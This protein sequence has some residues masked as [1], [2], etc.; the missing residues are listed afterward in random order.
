M[1]VP[2]PETGD[3]SR[4]QRRAKKRRSGRLALRALAVLAVVALLGGIAWV[5]AGMVDDDPTPRPP[6]APE[7]DAAAQGPGPALVVLTDD[8]GEVYA[9]TILVPDTS[10]IVHV[11]PGTLVEVP[12][13]GLASLAE[14][15][16]E[17]GDDL[18]RQSL[19]NL[20][21]ARLEH[22]LRLDRAALGVLLTDV[23]PLS[24]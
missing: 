5:V 18:V 12:S 23:A 9:L 13:L 19:E 1:T 10:T 3:G 16:A 4:R 15:A 14:A 24:V 21:G 11:P 17:G 22:V 7:Q 8:D 6:T 2:L 20:L